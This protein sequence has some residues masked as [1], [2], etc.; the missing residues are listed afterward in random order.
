MSDCINNFEFDCLHMRTIKLIN[1]FDI[2]SCGDN[3]ESEEL[4]PL[5][6]NTP[7]N[8]SII[9]F[10]N[11][12]NIEGD[13]ICI[14]PYI[15]FCS[16]HHG[17]LAVQH[18]IIVLHLK[19]KWR[20][21]TE[22]LNCLAGNLTQYFHLKYIKCFR[23]NE[24]EIINELIPRIPFIQDLNNPHKMI[25]DTEGLKYCFNFWSEGCDNIKSF[26]NP[27][28]VKMKEINIS[29]LFEPIKGIQYFDQNI[30]SGPYPYISAS[31]MNNGITGFVNKFSYDTKDENIISVAGFGSSGYCFVQRGKIA[32]RGH[33]SIILIKLKSKYKHLTNSLSLIAYWMTQHFR[34]NYTFHTALNNTRLMKESITLPTINN[35]LNPN[36]MNWFCY[37]Y[38]I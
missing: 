1:L 16:V 7:H 26:Y 4:V 17:K 22:C 37:K 33:G 2:V 8:N 27:S 34:T 13:Y 24:R 35:E 12:Y 36:L 3:V 23:I 10:V 25:I 30:E 28:A 9:K 29:E 15:G 31:S 20:H 32:V 19:S 11:Y 38:F 18:N 14:N 5:I 21:L 6:G